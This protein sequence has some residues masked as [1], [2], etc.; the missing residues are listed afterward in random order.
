MGKKKVI[1]T[2]TDSILLI[3]KIIKRNLSFNYPVLFKRD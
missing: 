2:I 1:F 3:L